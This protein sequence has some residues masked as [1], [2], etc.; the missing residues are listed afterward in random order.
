MRITFNEDQTKILVNAQGNEYEYINKGFPGLYK[1]GP[2]FTMPARVRIA[3]NL[4]RR[5]LSLYP[6]AII[7]P[8]VQ[9]FIDSDFKLKDLPSDFKYYTD[10]K[11]HQQIALRYV[12]SV[13][14]GGLLLEPGMGKTKVALD[15][16]A[17]R[18][19]KRT[20]IVCPKALLFVWQTEVQIH[21]PD[22]SVYIVKSTDWEVEK[23]KAL[24]H[25]IVV[26]N[27]DKAVS[28]AVEL[29]ECNFEFIA[30]DEA[31]IKD[32]KTERTKILTWLSKRI[33]NKMLMS[34]TLVNNTPLDVF[35]PIRFLEPSL[36]GTSFTK[37]KDV[38]TVQVSMGL[39]KAVVGFRKVPELKS[40]L[41]SVSIIMTKEQWL[42]L[43]PKKFIDIYVQPSN[44]QREVYKQLEANYIAYVGEQTIEIDNPLVALTKLIQIS[45]GFVYINNE[46]AVE[47]LMGDIKSKK[48]KSRST[49]FF[50]EQPKLDRLIKLLN[51]EVKGHR[52]V[53]WFNMAAEYELI[54]KRLEQE[55][56][57]FLTI[58]GGEKQTG[59]KVNLFNSDA[60]YRLLVCQAKS[61]NYG[62]TVLGVD[63]LE[64][65]EY[66][67][68]PGI[69]RE[70]FTQIFYSMNFSLE[71]YLQ[72]Q[73]RIHRLGQ[74][75]TC[76][77][78]HIICNTPAEIR[79]KEAIE[80]KKSIRGAVL[81][82]VITQLGLKL[83]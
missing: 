67:I 25:D 52:A 58:K 5:L 26:I 54:S 57:S 63:G 20:L 72:Q 47:D 41:D 31:L 60:S 15:F 17:V 34:G 44:H 74:E 83:V 1:E 24:S 80:N 3:Y 8:T 2:Y 42:K 18:K 77:Y 61:V 22:K 7:E 30:L 59:L 40:I 19:F 70:V 28:L 10:P 56:I 37:F 75:F 16:I 6:N 71:V 43:P 55:E 68:P 65:S 45:N 23:E 33:P 39:R 12:H 66:E 29:S 73:D 79:V 82:D 64:K 27:Y 81:Q 62:V 48:I 32:P 14:G 11:P 13:N 69:T 78:Y 76:Y 53:L 38:Y 36:V 35:A 21:R 51:E 49:Y 50:H 9:Q 4:I 46:D